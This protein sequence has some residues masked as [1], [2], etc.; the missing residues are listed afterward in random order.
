MTDE[1]VD[2]AQV[3]RNMREEHGWAKAQAMMLRLYVEAL[4]EAE[5]WTQRGKFLLWSV[6][7]VGLAAV[8]VAVWAVIATV[9]LVWRG[10]SWTVTQLVG[11]ARSTYR[12]YKH[13]HFDDVLVPWIR[14]IID[15]LIKMLPR[16]FGVRN[17]TRKQQIDANVVLIGVAFF[18][19]LFT[20]GAAWAII[21]LWAALL[22]FA[23]FFRGTPAGESYWRRFRNWLPL[24]NDY[25][26][27]FWRSE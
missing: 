19:G 10:L 22:L 24:S 15:F 21:F 20:G 9:S 5:S 13:F 4:F 8:A 2:P 1:T 17:T 16:A 11:L 14:G 6:V 25:N 18:S 12:Y 7:Y 26:I 23:F 27:P 3:G